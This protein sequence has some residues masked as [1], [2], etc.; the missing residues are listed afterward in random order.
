MIS[1]SNDMKIRYFFF[2]ILLM[3]S[4]VIDTAVYSLAV[5]SYLSLKRANDVKIMRN[6]AEFHEELTESTQNNSQMDTYLVTDKVDSNIE[7]RKY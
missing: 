5:K 7:E 4:L 1:K 3:S 6:Y 2:L